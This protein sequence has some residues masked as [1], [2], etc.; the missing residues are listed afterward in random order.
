[1]DD[2]QGE[3][4]VFILYICYKASLGIHL[5]LISYVNMYLFISIV[6]PE[7]GSATIVLTDHPKKFRERFRFKHQ[8]WKKKN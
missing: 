2:R 4:D 7:V 5:I 3:N 6:L 1:M 8:R